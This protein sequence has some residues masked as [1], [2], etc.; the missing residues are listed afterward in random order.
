MNVTDALRLGRDRLAAGGVPAPERDAAILLERATGLPR[1]ALRT[2][3][4]HEIDATAAGRFEGLL[5]LRAA[6]RPMSQ[7]LGEQEFRSR[8]F[9]VT[10]AVLAP[11]PETEDLVEEALRSG[12]AGARFAEAGV[13][14]GALVVSI[15]AE[16]PHGVVC[17][18]DISGGALAVAG[19][20]ARRHGVAERVVLRRG[21]LWAPLADLGPFDVMVSNPPYVRRSE[22]G[23]VDP[24][25]LWEPA[26]AVFC[27]GEPADLYARIAAE[28]APLLRPGGVLLLELPGPESEPVIAAVRGVA[29]YGEVS[30]RPDLAGHPRVLRAVR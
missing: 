21:D 27:D 6:R 7:I 25:V 17:G 13:G 10:P 9:R 4:S 18:S 11:R 1:T 24:E 8:P 5:A 19:E 15:A 16:R 28:A 12:G 2:Q 26:C 23:E 22:A 30:F 3:P 14:S 20:N 29:G